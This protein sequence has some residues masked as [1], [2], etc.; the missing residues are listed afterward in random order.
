MMK[1]NSGLLILTSEKEF[2]TG[3]RPIFSLQVDFP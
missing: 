2:L 1:L 3:P